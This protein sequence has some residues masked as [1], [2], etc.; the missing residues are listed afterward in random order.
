MNRKNKKFK[1]T[2]LFTVVSVM[3]I[4]LIFLLGTLVLAAS[5]NKRTHR[6]YASTQAE[7]AARSAIE[8]FLTAM[9]NNDAIAADVENLT[10]GSPMY[11]EV[12]LNSN[13]YGTLATIDGHDRSIKVEVDNTSGNNY[14]FND[15]GSNKGWQLYNTIKVTAVAELGKEQGSVVAYIRKKAPHEPQPCAIKGL[16]TVDGGQ[17]M[18]STKATFTGG[19]GVG[20]GQDDPANVL[21]EIT[22]DPT[23]ENDL[24]YINGSID[25]KTQMNIHAITPSSGTVVMGDVSIDNAQFVNI[26]YTVPS[27]MTVDQVPYLYVEG[28]MNFEDKAIIE[29]TNGQPYNIFA[30][31]IPSTGKNNCKIEADLYLT[32]NNQTSNIGHQT[33][34]GSELKKWSNSV[35]NKTDSNV[36]STGGNIY[37]KGNVNLGMISIDGDVRVERNLSIHNNAI[38]KGNIICGGKVTL[39]DTFL[40]NYSNTVIYCNEAIVNGTSFYKASGYD[41]AG[42]WNDYDG[43]EKAY[44]ERLSFKS[45]QDKIASDGPIYPAI[46][47][48]AVITNSSKLQPSDPGYNKIVPSLKEVREQLNYNEELD[49]QGNPTGNYKF[50]PD[51]FLT[52]VPDDTIRTECAGNKIDTS[53]SSV[54]VDKNCTFTGTYPSLSKVIFKTSGGSDLWVVMD[55]AVFQT[56]LDFEIDDSNGGKVNFLLKATSTSGAYSMWVN[57]LTMHTSDVYNG[58]A[59]LETT[60]ISVNWYGD[61]ITN[62]TNTIYSNIFSQNDS[63]FVGNALCPYSTYTQK[64]QGVYSS[65]EYTHPNGVTETISKPGW[66][67]SALFRDCDVYN[68]FRILY[69]GASSSSTPT[70][71]NNNGDY[72]ILYFNEY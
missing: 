14:I 1:G 67:G 12:N 51:I 30:G 20:L 22:N 7:F 32:M 21:L 68:E 31:Y 63:T 15:E 34:G 41:D 2:V 39:S 69:A 71:R 45:V 25:G 47:E 6:T 52:D 44:N 46:M 70:S 38:I 10:A 36:F 62:G 33:A 54:E 72:Q 9:E 24:T 35:Y 55:Q 3:S 26:D 23:F 11:V 56:A 42:N 53:L 65:V 28:C 49:A 4:L 60:P 40:N 57:K 27:N 18:K 58:A 17:F 50:D 19:L 43:S 5:A 61:Y 64:V 59:I 37:S 8:S 66:I 29:A 13:A 16:Q 48:K